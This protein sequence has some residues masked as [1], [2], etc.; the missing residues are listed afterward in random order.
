MNK[1][2]LCLTVLVLATAAFSLTT[3]ETDAVVKEIGCHTKGDVCWVRLDRSTADCK[4]VAGYGVSE[5]RWYNT[6]ENATTFA[7]LS[8]AKKN[9][10]TVNFAVITDVPFLQWNQVCTFDH[11][12]VK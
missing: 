2:I 5:L 7:M 10:S 8:M 1:K 4:K 3:A 11:F 12:T 9:G 6:A